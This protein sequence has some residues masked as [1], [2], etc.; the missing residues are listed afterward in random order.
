MGR[1]KRE[2]LTVTPRAAFAAITEKVI[3]Q[4]KAR[5]R[6]REIEKERLVAWTAVKVEREMVKEERAVFCR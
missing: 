2:S 6:E 3:G 4:R 1:G 5:R